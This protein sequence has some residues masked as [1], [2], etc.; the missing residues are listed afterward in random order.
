MES[1]IRKMVG[2]LILSRIVSLKDLIRNPNNLVR[3]IERKESIGYIHLNLEGSK[4]YKN[5]MLDIDYQISKAKE[6][7]Y[8]NRLLNY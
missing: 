3:K 8:R 2:T 6:L 7:F 4:I 1:S 5:Q